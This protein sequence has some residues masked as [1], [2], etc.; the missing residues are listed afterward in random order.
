MLKVPVVPA[1]VV[2]IS[3]L[4]LGSVPGQLRPGEDRPEHAAVR[5]GAPARRKPRKTI[6]LRQPSDALAL[7]HSHKDSRFSGCRASIS[8]SQ[9]LTSREP[10]IRGLARSSDEGG[11]AV[12]LQNPRRHRARNLVP[13]DLQR[14]AVS[15]ALDFPHRKRNPAA[16]PATGLQPWL[17]L[18]S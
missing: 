2:F 10:L 17:S 18:C 1:C 15:R 5:A 7:G 11:L 8:L 13:G 4:S 3:C 14:K 12:T 6:T 9:F 16:L